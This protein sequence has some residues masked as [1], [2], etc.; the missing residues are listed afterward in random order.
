MVSGGG[1]DGDSSVNTDKIAL[2]PYFLATEI[3]GVSL[4]IIFPIHLL[5]HPFL[6]IELI[7]PG[8][9]EGQ[10]KSY[11]FR[12][13]SFFFYFFFKS[14]SLGSIW[15]NIHQTVGIYFLE[16]TGKMDDVK[17]HDLQRSLFPCSLGNV[18]GI[19][20]PG[21]VFLLTLPRE[22]F[23]NRIVSWCSLRAQYSG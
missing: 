7:L 17:W 21:K 23:R 9:E 8:Q 19:T 5:T 18:L 15:F 10:R 12:E 3:F 1:W 11:F 4:R 14:H 6:N 16:F 13:F 22:N 20:G 2:L